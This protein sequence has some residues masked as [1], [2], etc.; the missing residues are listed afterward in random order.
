[1]I[2]KFSGSVHYANGDPLSNVVVRIYDKDRS[3][4]QDDDLTT[5]PGVSDGQG[6]F[7]L[8]YE[9]LRYLDYHTIHAPGTP[10]EPFNLPSSGSGLRLPDLGDVY[11]PYLQFNY[12]LN[13]LIHQH[14]ASMGIFRTE[15]HLPENPPV[16]FLPSEH[17]FRFVNSFSGYFL[18]FSTPAFMGSRKVSAKYGLCGG[19]CAA[20]YDFALAGRAIPEKKDIPNQGTRLQRYLFRRQMDSLGGMAQQIVKVAQW[21]SMPDDT[22]FGTQAHT[23]DEFNPIRQKL[24]DQNPVVLALIYEHASTLKQLSRLIFNNHQV[25]AYGYQQDA[26]GGITIHIYDP[27]LPGRDDVVIRSEPVVLVELTSPSGPQTV[28]GLKSAQWVGGVFYREGRGYFAMPY[29]PELPPKGI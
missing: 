3:G 8:T 7:S 29:V 1:M 16:E 12:N 10:E 2:I 9:P 27:N 23:A 24:N 28:M 13:G 11:L 22:L 14:T 4:E 15:F 20:A 18:P 26:G 19:M 5:T 25:L 17:G 6:R 21:T